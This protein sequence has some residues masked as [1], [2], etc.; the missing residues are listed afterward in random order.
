MQEQYRPQDIEPK[1]QADWDNNKTFVVQEDPNKEKFYCLSMFPYPS[2]RLHMGHVRNYTIGDVISRYQRLQGK[3]VMQPIGWDAF[4]LPAEN[5]AVKNKTAPAPWTYENIEYMKNQLKL[6]GFGYDWDREFATC[7]PEYYRWEQEFFT[8][9]Y[10][11]GLVYKKTSSVNWCPNDQTVLANE[12]VEDGCCWRCDTPVEQKEIPQW[13]IKITAYAQELLDDLDTLEGWPDMVKTMQRNWIGRSEGVELSFN[14]ADNPVLEV[15]TTRPD[16]LMGVTYVGIAAGHPLA[17]KAAETNPALAAFIDECRN[18][19]VAEAELATMEKKGMDTGLKA[20][21]PLNGLEVPIFVANFV[22]MDYGTGAV[23]AVPGHDQ[24]DFEFATKY[25]LEITP[26]ILAEDGNAPDISEAAHTEKGVLFNSG[27]FDGL[28]FE[29]AFDAIAAKLESEGKGHKTVNFRLRDWGVSRQR[30]WGSPIPM[31]TTEDGQVHP[32]PADQLPVILPED[33]VMDGVTS[34]I[35][36]DKTWAETTFNG[37]PAL[38]ETDTFDTFMESSWYYARYC[39][40]KA[41]QMLD[42]DAANYW[43]PVDQYVG[44]IEHAVMHL[45]YSRFFHKLLRDAGMVESD[46]PFKQLLCQGMVLADAYY[47]NNEKGGKVWV[48]PTDVTVERDEKGRITSAVDTEGNNLVHSGMTKMSK[49]KNN[50]I[51]PQEMVDKYGADTVR[52]F[53]MFASPADMTLEWQESGVEGANRFLKRIWKLVFDH[54]SKGA[55]PKIMEKQGAFVLADGSVFPKDLT[56]DQKT[57]RREVHKT[58]AKVSDDIGRRQTFNTA[59]AAVMELMNRLSKAPQETDTDRAIL[60][61]ALKAV[62]V[63]LYPITP[64]ISN[65]LWTALGE[66]D[67]DHAAWPEADQNAMIEDEKL[68]IVQVNGKLRAKITVAADAAKDDVEAMAQN[69]EHVVKFTEGKTIRKVIYVPGKLV[70][71]VAS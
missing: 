69:D 70:N 42:S 61:E 24:R 66:T 28:A 25:G 14:V 44:G 63:M 37:E 54:T 55:V 52:L 65:E 17:A 33:V 2:G 40:P 21:H 39:S 3:N 47:Y 9:L 53:M 62:V 27:E 59:I 20:I 41:D 13:F 67:A 49:S 6:L 56:S 11:K 26:V 35:K 45:L 50:G 31:V 64:H 60:D 29:A 32:V 71:I 5:A 10:E 38:R 51:D 1:V 34:P 58:I 68:I 48:S 7:T 18:T 8:K 4:G 46:E 22:L 15:Y 12:Q 16:T 23:M 30:Y 36:A 19:K 57:L 43:L